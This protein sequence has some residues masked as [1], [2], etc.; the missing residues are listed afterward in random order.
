MAPAVRKLDGNLRAVELSC[1]MKLPRSI[2]LHVLAGT[3][4]S[5]RMKFHLVA[6][7]VINLAVRKRAVL[8][9]NFLN[10]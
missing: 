5:T 9:L 4:T 10:S 3:E 2:M 1:E 6:S 8:F 7:S